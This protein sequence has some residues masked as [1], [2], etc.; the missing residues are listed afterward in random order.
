MATREEGRGAAPP[1]R[2]VPGGGEQPHTQAVGAEH[3]VD[4]FRDAGIDTGTAT[5]VSRLFAA[6]D[7]AGPGAE[8]LT[9]VIEVIKKPARP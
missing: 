8:G 2:R 6:A 7:A 5:A 9:S 4:T 1:R 3:V